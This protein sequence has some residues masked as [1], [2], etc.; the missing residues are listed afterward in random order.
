MTKTVYALPKNTSL[1]S[2]ILN[3]EFIEVVERKPAIF[4]GG[5]PFIVEVGLAY[6]G[7]AGRNIGDD[8]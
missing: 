3:P 4:R 6:G 5:I 8:R 1:K 7:G 2:I